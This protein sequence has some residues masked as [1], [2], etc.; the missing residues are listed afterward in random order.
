[1]VAFTGCGSNTQTAEEIEAQQQ[2]EQE[3]ARYTSEL[4]QNDYRGGVQRCGVLKSDVLEVIENM[5]ANNITVREDNPNGF[6][7]VD[8]YQDFVSTFLTTSVINDTQWF[9]EEEISADDP[10][11]NWESTLVQMQSCKLSFTKAGDSGYSFIGTV[12]RN[13]KDDYSVTNVPFTIYIDNAKGT[14]YSGNMNLRI[15]YDCDKDWC[16]A[17]GSVYNDD[18][19]VTI[20]PQMFEFMRIDNDTF[21]VQTETERLLVKLKPTEEDV[22]IREREISEFYYSKLVSDG[23]RT[24]FEPYTPLPEYDEVTMAELK[25]NINKNELMEKYSWLNENG[26]IATRYGASDSIFYRTPSEI[27]EDNFVFE[28][29][30]LQQAICYKDGVLVATT[31][32][33]LSTE[34]E[35]FTYSYDDVEKSLID[36]LENKV[37]IQNLIGSSVEIGSE[38]TDESKEE[39]DENATTEATV[40]E[41]TTVAVT[42]EQTTNVS[43]EVANEN[44]ENAEEITAEETTEK[45]EEEVETTEAE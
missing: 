15:L 44:P 23:M 19:A 12:T 18:L 4:K 40:T 10:D 43:E 28:D 42:T 2:A 34:Y 16:K 38:S 37:Q 5:K 26:D 41:M 32:N 8:G 21:A 29:K 6:W 30:A 17:Y 11:A 1:M 13:E 27:T 9:N 33:K 20:T 22:D 31:Y 25:A 39:T 3:E 7:N 35:Q 45:V 14:T 36:E 24:T